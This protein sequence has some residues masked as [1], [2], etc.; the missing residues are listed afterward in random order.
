MNQNADKKDTHNAIKKGIKRIQETVKEIR[1]NFSKAI[2]SGSRSGRIE[3]EFCEDLV[4]IWGG[5]DYTKPLEF[6]TIVMIFFDQMNKHKIFL[7]LKTL[8]TIV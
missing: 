3:E 2:V 6:D 1:R 4:S 7:N 8:L 5:S